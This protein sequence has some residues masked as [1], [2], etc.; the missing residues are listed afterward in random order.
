MGL[1]KYN[2]TSDVPTL[3]QVQKLFISV[4]Q[5]FGKGPG[6]VITLCGELMW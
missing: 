1:G 4:V 2:A 3:V 6:F 5:H